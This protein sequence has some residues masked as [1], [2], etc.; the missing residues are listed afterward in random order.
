[1]DEYITISA[2][3]VLGQERFEEIKQ[4]LRDY[5]NKYSKILR[6]KYLAS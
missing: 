1:M 5:T 6:N 4:D 3:N 2:E